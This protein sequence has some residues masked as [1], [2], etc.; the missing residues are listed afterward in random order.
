MI[1][2]ETLEERDACVAVVWG[3]EGRDCHTKLDLRNKCEQ[4]IREMRESAR[5][6][7]EAE[8]QVTIP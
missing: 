4:V 5:A 7:K 2:P 1:R 3:D 8:D 6:L